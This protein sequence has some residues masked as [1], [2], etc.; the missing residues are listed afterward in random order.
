MLVQNKNNMVMTFRMVTGEEVLA[1]VSQEDDHSFTLKKPLVLTPIPSQG[2]QPPG[3]A[4]VP[5]LMSV[6]IETV[7]VTINKAAVLASGATRKEIADQ[8]IQNTTG[9]SP[10]SSLVGIK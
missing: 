7:E 9:I 2:G 3:M 10:V 5:L 4:L 6:D 8:Y 1:R